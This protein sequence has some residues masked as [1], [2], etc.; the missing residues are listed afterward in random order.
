LIST[1][2]GL[3]RLTEPVQRHSKKIMQARRLRI[4]RQCP[5][6]RIDR[7]AKQPLLAPC[8]CQIVTRVRI[9]RIV[10]QQAVVAP[11]GFIESP[12]PV[13][14]QCILQRDCGR[15]TR[16]ALFLKQD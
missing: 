8:H 6:N 5:A 4:G 13:Q 3:L 7:L 10:L 2:E 15:G 11:Y 1:R 9:R 14:K 12:L 16:H